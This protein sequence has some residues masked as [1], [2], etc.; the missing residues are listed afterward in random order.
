LYAKRLNDPAGGKLYKQILNSLF[1]KTLAKC[2]KTVKYK[3]FKTEA[4]A[5][6]YARQHAPRLVKLSECDVEMQRCYDTFYNFAYIGVAILSYARRIMNELFDECSGKGI[7]VYMS[8]TDS[9][10]IDTRNVERLNYRIGKQLGRLKVEAV[11]VNAI[12]ERANC[13]YLSADHCRPKDG[14][15]GTP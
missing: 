8:N 6:L 2:F 5:E 11:G 10:L 13:Y 14:Y 1:G 15:W 7:A 12:V 9:L 4:G 3:T